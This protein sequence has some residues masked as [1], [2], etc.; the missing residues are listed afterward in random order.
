ML[1][2][3]LN[4]RWQH[5]DPQVRRQAVASLTWSEDADAI[6]QVARDDSLPALR[7]MA[8]RQSPDLEM[9][10]ERTTE[11]LDAAVR[12][13]ATNRYREVLAGFA[14]NGPSLTERLA[15]AAR[16][17]DVQLLEFLA[18]ESK[19]D[20]LRAQA[21]ARVERE[22]VLRD[23]ALKDPNSELRLEALE[24]IQDEGVLARVYEQSRK[25]DKLVSRRARERLEANKAQRELPERVAAQCLQICATLESL[26]RDGYWNRD[27]ERFA[28][29]ESRWQ[30]LE[31]G[32]RHDYEQRFESARGRFCEALAANRSAEPP[33]RDAK[34]T[35]IARLQRANDAAADETEDIAARTEEH[36]SMLRD[37]GAAW[38]RIEQLP[39]AE[40]QREL[41]NRFLAATQA[42]QESLAANQRRSALASLRARFDDLVARKGV[43]AE[44]DVKALERERE[45]LPA[46]PVTGALSTPERQIDKAHRKLRDRLRDQASWKEA[47]LAAL[48][49]RLDALKK[50]VADG[51]ASDAIALHDAVASDM[52]ALRTMGASKERMTPHQSRLRAVAKEVQVMRAWGRFGATRALERLCEEMEALQ[53]S[54]EHPPELARTIRAARDAWKK[55]SANGPGANQGLWKRFD[56]AATEAYLPC[57]AYFEERAKE[58]KANLKRRRQ[59]LQELQILVDSITGRPGEDWKK[60]VR[61]RG[62][63]LTKWHRAFPV[64]R[65]GAK[66]VAEDFD[67]R[68]AELNAVLGRERA[69]SV[70]HR[71]QL[72]S[73][74]EALAENPDKKATAEA[75]KQL[76][77]QWSTTVPGSRSEENALWGRF[78]GACD[79]V[80]AERQHL[81]D[82]E[83][84]SAKAG[85]EARKVLCERV[86]ALLQVGPADVEEAE[87]ELRRAQGEW[88]RIERLPK[89]E[90]DALESRFSALVRRFADHNRALAATA[91][92]ADLELMRSKAMLCHEAENQPHPLDEAARAPA[93]ALRSRW[94]VLPA[95]TDDDD[96]A[97]MRARFKQALTAQ[98]GADDT[99]DGDVEERV[100]NLRAR[101]SLCLRLEILTGVDSPPEYAQARMAHQVERL[102]SALQARSDTDG[103]SADELLR[104]W[105]LLGPAPTGHANELEARFYKTWVARQDAQ[106]GKPTGGKRAAH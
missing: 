91:K 104:A 26:G 82:A 60:I 86:E 92:Q 12:K 29:L 25:R 40:E 37:A 56:A 55:Q 53:E 8:L 5:P 24:R 10:L 46:Q 87:R 97:A 62:E 73:E 61:T 95:L 23:V 74:V 7:L 38:K 33:L 63:L 78:R 84:E 76:Q 1:K 89:R 49:A 18:R 15:R 59:L 70:R 45:A 54:Q 94:Q 34:Q 27:E 64:E 106:P 77:R 43:I 90:G 14:E 99:P 72:I 93:A 21:L 102:S 31:P 4:P 69:R 48:P 42:M 11:D 81:F 44:G 98:H 50:A 88:G 51:Q 57:K 16:I 30:S 83:R 65:K 105:C 85:I 3:F 100:A 68:M 35:L 66:A 32:Y 79:V 96:E 20:A 52:E 9:L 58:R 103:E 36:A 13:E 6:A 75:C 101:Q 39:D 28:H 47:T 67:S 41:E 80:F 22:T 71:E 19:D 2:R 17:N